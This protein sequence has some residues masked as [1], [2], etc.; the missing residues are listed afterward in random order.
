MPPLEAVLV[1][2]VL[3]TVLSSLAYARKVLTWDGSLAAFAVGLLIG[4]FGDVLWLFLLLLFLVT[5]FLATRYRFEQKRRMGQQE[6]ARGERRY[7]N[8]LANGLAPTAVAIVGG[9]GLLGWSREL[10]GLLFVSAIAVAA[11]DTMASE[12]GVLSTRTYRITT[13]ERVVPGTNGGVSLLGQGAALGAALY[14]TLMAWI[15]LSLVP[16]R[17]GWAAT[18]P[19]APWILLI[20][21]AVGF[22]GCQVDS[23]V[24]ATWE[25]RGWVDKKTNNLLVTSLGVVLAYAL[26]LVLA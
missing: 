11:A 16:P 9:V 3:T 1:T 7:T 21:I 4:V 20:P 6:G 2:V 23:I 19:P 8:V 18:F 25:T 14:T 13:G 15:F 17:M 22:L 10:S 24:G 26:Y 5:S 12:I